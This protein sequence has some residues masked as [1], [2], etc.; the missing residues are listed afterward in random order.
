MANWQI[1]L[2]ASWHA[3][4]SVG[5]DLGKTGFHVVALGAAGTMLAKR[6]HANAATDTRGQS[7]RL[8]LACEPA[9]VLTSSDPN[10]EDE[11]FLNILYEQL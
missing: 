1:E 7:S 4:R 2:G 3:E 8:L 6:S 11:L 9:V 5:T 10:E